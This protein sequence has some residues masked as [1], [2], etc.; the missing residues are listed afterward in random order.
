MQGACTTSASLRAARCDRNARRDQGQSFRPR[1]ASVHGRSRPQFAQVSGRSPVATSSPQVRHAS[2]PEATFCRARSARS[3]SGTS[4]SPALSCAARTVLNEPPG[5]MYGR[6]T[7]PEW[8]MPS[9]RSWACTRSSG[10]EARFFFDGHESRRRSSQPSAARVAPT[11]SAWCHALTRRGRH[12]L[13]APCRWLWP[14]CGR[15]C[16]AAK[17]GFHATKADANR[18]RS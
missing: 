1:T 16:R 8:V 3:Q 2:H 15:A 9:E 10:N 18:D 12:A 6:S 14:E 11:P 5:S 4:E 17:G 7:S 13:T